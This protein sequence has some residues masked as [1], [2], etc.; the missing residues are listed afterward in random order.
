MS[1]I[2]ELVDRNALKL[3]LLNRSEEDLEIL[4]KF[5]LWKIRDPKTMNMLLYVLNLLVEYYGIVIGNNVKI[6]ALFKQIK[7]AVDK[8]I[9]F[10]KDLLEIN[11]KLQ[12]IQDIHILLN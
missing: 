4:M 7:E 8:E 2:E 6:D 10:E 9:E 12:S 1:V 11:Q 3:A 5:I